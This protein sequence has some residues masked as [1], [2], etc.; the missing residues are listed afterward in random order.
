VVS[1]VDNG[2]VAVA[3]GS[4]RAG[5]GAGLLLSAA[6]SLL[7]AGRRDWGR[8]MLAELASIGPGPDRWRFALSCVRATLANPLATFALARRLVWLGVLVATVVTAMHISFGYLR[9]EAL[10]MV[11]ALGGVA[12]LAR[13]RWAFGPA[14]PGGV[15]RALRAGGFALIAA[16]VVIGINQMRV[17]PPIYVDY[18]PRVAD[19]TL[20]VVVVSTIL[21]IYLVALAR[22]TAGRS[23]VAAT[24]VASGAGAGVLGALL[25]TVATLIVP[26]VPDTMGPALWTVLAAAVAAGAWSAR[27]SGVRQAIVATLCAATTAGLLIDLIIEHVLP[28]PGHWVGN[29]HP[30]VYPASSVDRLV[31]PIGIMIVGCLAALALSIAIRRRPRPA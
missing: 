8:A 1:R 10:L 26:S 25:F 12:W 28:L 22:V 30:P 29:S 3:V 13:S 18:T 6:V 16:Q 15:A 31:D 19:A 17:S 11:A 20:E 27:R 24:T 4:S 5:G 23:D 21:A 2:D 14:A 9:G 7:P